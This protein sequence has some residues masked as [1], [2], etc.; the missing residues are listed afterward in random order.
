MCFTLTPSLSHP[1]G[2]GERP[3]RDQQLARSNSLTRCLVSLSHRM[4][5]GRGE[6][7]LPAKLRR[8]SFRNVIE[9][10]AKPFTY[11]PRETI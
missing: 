7:N 4:G 8:A 5:E 2:E 9:S 11:Q 10:A 3:V 1:M 6:G